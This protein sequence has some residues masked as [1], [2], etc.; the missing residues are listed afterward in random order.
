MWTCA[1]LAAF[2]CF[3]FFWKIRHT[4][5]AMVKIFGDQAT[6]LRDMVV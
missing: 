2:G 5:L 4:L 3:G 1:K 6:V